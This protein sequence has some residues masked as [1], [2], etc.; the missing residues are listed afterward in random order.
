MDFRIVR[1]LIAKD[2]ALFFRNR[3]YAVMTPVALIA[4]IAIYFVMPSSIDETLEIGFYSEGSVGGALAEGIQ[5][6]G[7]NIVP[8]ES[9]EMLK[10][11]VIDARY[12]AGVVVGQGTEHQPKFTLYF[13]SDTLDEMMGS[14]KMLLSDV[15]AIGFSTPITVE[16]TEEVL[17]P[18]LIGGQI[19]YRDRLVPMLAVLVILIETFGLATLIAEEVQRRTIVSLLV[20]PARFRELFTAKAVVG[21]GLA[22]VQA[23]LFLLVVGGLNTEPVIILFALL[24]GSILVTGVGFLMAALGKDL[25]SVMAWGV[26]AMVPLTIPSFE[27]VFPGTLSSWVEF[28]PTYYLVDTVHQAANLGAGWSDVASSLLILLGINVLVLWIGVV[29]LQRRLR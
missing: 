29:A 27:V 23:V 16:F 28:I 20:T 9:E 4:Y 10:E 15:L 2:V 13:A 19:S 17:G 1:V 5:T 25:L 3:L 24:L 18:D 6:D 26:V 14:V 11:A 7:L 8:V 21:V 22:F 12:V